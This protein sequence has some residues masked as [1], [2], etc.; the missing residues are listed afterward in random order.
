[1]TEQEWLSGTNPLSLREYLRLHHNPSERKLRL[2]AIACS[3]RFR[4]L[5]YDERS[6]QAVE[7]ANSF[8]EGKITHRERVKI[9]AAAWE[10]ANEAKADGQT[11]AAIAAAVAAARMVDG[12]WPL[13]AQRFG[14]SGELGQQYA[15]SALQDAIFLVD[16]E[17]EC[18]WL[19]DLFGN[20]FRPARVDPSWLSSN[21]RGVA[22]AIYEERAFDQLAVLSD[23]LEEAGCTN[24][25]ILNHCRGSAAH[26]RGCWVVDLLLGK[27]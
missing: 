3:A 24:E 19:R 21:V 5:L 8:V 15:W 22:Q 10:A 25:D 1:M 23:A 17:E 26:A 16:G 2:L 20:P 7:A 27:E 9:A 4:H 12:D 13:F 14:S 11:G 18:A 6:R